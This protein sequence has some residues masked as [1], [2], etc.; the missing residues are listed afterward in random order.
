MHITHLPI[1]IPI[2]APPLGPPRL[3]L[4]PTRTQHPLLL[5]LLLP[6]SLDKRTQRRLLD[7]HI[8]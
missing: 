1:P 7:G 4:A 3:V 8:P 2:F 6:Q 5:F